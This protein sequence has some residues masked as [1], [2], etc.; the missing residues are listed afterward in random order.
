MMLG[1]LCGG[2]NLMFTNL[3]MDSSLVFFVVVIV[4]V[5]HHGYK[6]QESKFVQQDILRVR[7]D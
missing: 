2:G 3:C 6:G 4:V 5:S 1:K 7:K